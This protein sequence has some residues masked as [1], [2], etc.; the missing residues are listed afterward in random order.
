MPGDPKTNE[1]ISLKDQFDALIHGESAREDS[2]ERLFD[3]QVRR[4]FG[5]WITRVCRSKLVVDKLQQQ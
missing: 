5:E 4:R 3:D 2:I 1:W